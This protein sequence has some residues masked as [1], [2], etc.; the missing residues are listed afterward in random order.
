MR[1]AHEIHLRARGHVLAFERRQLGVVGSIVSGVLKPILGEPTTT[2]RQPAQTTTTTGGVNP[3]PTTTPSPAGNT[4]ILAKGDGGSTA[5]PN[6]GTGN[7]RIVGNAASGRTSTAGSPTG[8]ASNPSG[9]SSPNGNRGGTS[10]NTSSGGT[11]SGTKGD[12]TNGDSLKG[13]GSG[14]E[15]NSGTRGGS[16]GPSSEGSSF[17]ISGS[18]TS[19]NGDSSSP[20]PSDVTTLGDSK[21]NN[22][23]GGIIAAAVILTLLFSIAVVV[24]ILRRRS[25]ARRDDQANRWWFTRKRTSQAYGDGEALNT[26][27]SSRRSSFATTVDHSNASFLAKTAI[28]P[29]PPMAE[30]GRSNGAAPTLVLDINADPRFSI[31]SA[32]SHN[33]QFLIIHHR[34]SLLHEATSSA[35]TEAFPFPK[36]PI[37]DRASLHSKAS[38][39]SE[40]KQDGDMFCVPAPSSPSRPTQPQLPADPFADTNPFEDPSCVPSPIPDQNIT[41]T[42][43]RP[44]F[45]QLQDELQVDIGDTVCILQS[46]DDGWAFAEKLDASDGKQGFIPLECFHEIGQFSSCTTRRSSNSTEGLN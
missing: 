11:T 45:P 37:A 42:V 17:S 44:F 26:G 36:P 41:G 9:S 35:C 8:A 13:S 18:G 30:V 23:H 12:S 3:D 34:E 28:P 20:S 19:G 1:A 40:S 31:G 16:S 24:C 5:S 27:N 4:A 6:S 46:F 22:S 2:Q 29:P 15:S 32:G 14:T 39:R 25:K 38:W 10:G 43:L 21:G 33:S 7:G